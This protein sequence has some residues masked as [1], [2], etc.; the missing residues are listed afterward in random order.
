MGK[1]GCNR[2]EVL[3]SPRGFPALVYFRLESSWELQ[4]LAENAGQGSVPAE[5]GCF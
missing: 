4:C 5:L 1:V 3:L 2:L